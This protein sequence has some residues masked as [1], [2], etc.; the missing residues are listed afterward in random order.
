MCKLLYCIS[1]SSYGGGG[2]S[3]LLLPR[4]ALYCRQLPNVSRRGG[5][6]RQTSRRLRHACH[7][8]KD[9][10]IFMTLQT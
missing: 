10:I 8:R 5:K 4:S 1:G 3:P 6:I 2:D 9:E 7:E